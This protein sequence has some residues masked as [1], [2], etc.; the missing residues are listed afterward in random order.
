[1]A[2]G[3]E[4]PRLMISIIAFP[5]LPALSLAVIPP[6]PASLLHSPSAPRPSQSYVS[7]LPLTCYLYSG[8][9]LS[10]S[11]ISFTLYCSSLLSLSLSLPFL[12][13]PTLP[14]FFFFSSWRICNFTIKVRIHFQANAVS[15][16][17]LLSMDDISGTVHTED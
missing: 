1:M 4:T 3:G 13:C 2:R 10:S 14:P 16:G 11:Y 12:F 7:S 6:S 5:F 8:P 9:L 15:G 17:C